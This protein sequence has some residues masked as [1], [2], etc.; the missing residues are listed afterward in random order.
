MNQES[1]IIQCRECKTKNRVPKARLNDKPVCGQCKTPLPRMTYHSMPVVVS[2]ATFRAEVLG[3]PGTVLL[4]CWAPWCGPCKMMGP[5]LDQV[6]REYAGRLKVAKI[7]VDQN[8][9]TS[10]TYSILSIPTLL[11]FKN[12]KLVGNVPGAVQKP[13]IDRQLARFL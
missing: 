3:Y 1:K 8:P 12:G 11:F 5:I 9:M 4:D 7:N 6:A 2:D 10:A 13:E